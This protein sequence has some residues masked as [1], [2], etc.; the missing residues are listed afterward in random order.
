MIRLATRPGKDA[1]GNAPAVSETWESRKATGC[2][3]IATR[4]R[5]QNHCHRGSTFQKIT[6][7]TRFSQG[8]RLTG[9]DRCQRKVEMSYWPRFAN[10]P[11]PSSENAFRT[12]RSGQGRAAVARRSEP[13]TASTVLDNGH[14]G[15]EEM[16]IISTLRR[17]GLG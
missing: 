3:R 6:I 11:F 12:A 5:P 14:G 9:V 8:A 13:L 2:Q 7:K 1:L 10:L 15:K 4:Y 17:Q 16:L